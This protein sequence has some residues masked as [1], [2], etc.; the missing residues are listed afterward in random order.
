MN[1]PRLSYP[2]APQ[3]AANPKDAEHYIKSQAEEIERLRASLSELL[4]EYVAA[5]KEGNIDTF[6]ATAK[7]IV[8][9]AESAL[10]NQQATPQKS[11]EAK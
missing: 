8:R 9:R 11:G 10:G 3:I 1:T 4:V 7:A 2:R 6:P 5:R